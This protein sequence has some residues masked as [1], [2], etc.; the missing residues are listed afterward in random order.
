MTWWFD[1]LMVSRL[2][3]WLFDDSMIGWFGCIII[4]IC[5]GL[6]V[7]WFD[8]LTIRRSDGWKIWRF[9]DL[10]IQRFDALTFDYLMAWR[11][12][13]LEYPYS[14][15]TQI[16]KKGGRAVGVHGAAFKLMNT[17]RTH[18]PSF[19][20]PTVFIRS[21]NHVPLGGC[22]ILTALE[23]LRWCR[24]P[25]VRFGGRRTPAHWVESRKS[26]LRSQKN[27][28]QIRTQKQYPEIRIQKPGIRNQSS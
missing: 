15:S 5:K 8:Y 21:R 28:S 17:R 22:M 9:S 16:R 25:T 11:I 3:T 1:G 27:N 7:S 6:T 23:E 2:V 10:I 18:V 24:T 4:W 20:V 19:T 12:L 26:E 13:L 14:D